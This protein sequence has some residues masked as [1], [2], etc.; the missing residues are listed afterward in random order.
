MVGEKG[1]IDTDIREAFVASGLAHILAISGLHMALVMTFIIFSARALLALN[2]SLSLN[3]P[4]RNIAI[5]AGLVTGGIYFLLSGGSISAT[6]AFIMVS[7]MALA[8]LFGRRAI[9]IRNIALACLI[10]LI[11]SPFALIGPGFQMS[12]AAT[13]YLVVFASY[14]IGH[15][16]LN[17]ETLSFSSKVFL[18]LKRYFLGLII[19]SVLA[20]V[21]TGLFAAFH[22]HRIAPLGLLANFLGVPIFAFLVMPFGFFG[23]LLMPFG[24]EA[25]PLMLMGQ[26]IDIIVQIAE[27]ISA[28]SNA[29]AATG[30]LNPKAFY[31]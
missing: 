16:T 21:S 6:R 19:T 7:I 3:Y 17:A 12:F 13:L 29:Y 22:F 9:S 2:A 23:L 5:Y 10:I 28:Y 4:I 25:F 1:N 24:Y 14:W 30:M 18:T 15:S 20:G 31:C 11:L 8:R 27:K 26:A